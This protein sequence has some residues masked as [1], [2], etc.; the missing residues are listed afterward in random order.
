MIELKRVIADDL[1]LLAQEADRVTSVL[2]HSAGEVDADQGHFSLIAIGQPPLFE[3]NIL[4][5]EASFRPAGG[6][7]VLVPVGTDQREHLSGDC[8]HAGY[9][10]DAR[11]DS[12][13]DGSAEQLG[14]AG[15][16][17]G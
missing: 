13:R 4:P 6:Q 14:G 15:P 9:L 17:D 5:E 7:H 3:R 1:K 10:G 12:I 2:L 11:A 16:S 8:R